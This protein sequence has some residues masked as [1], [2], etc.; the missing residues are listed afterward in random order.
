MSKETL[1]WLNNN[2]LIG[3]TEKRGT[4]WHYRE[5]LN[6]GE[7]N[8]YPGPIPVDD[9]L[10]RLFNFEVFPHPIYVEFGGEQVPVPGKKAWVCDDD[11]TVLGIFGDGYQGHAYSEWLIESVAKLLD[12]DLSIGSAGLL[13]NRGQAWVQVEVPETVVTPEGV[14]FRPHLLAATSFDG[15]LATVYKRSITNTVCDNTMTA[16]LGE[17]GEQVR[18]KHS[19][20]SHLR[21]ADARDALAIVYTLADDFASEV[22]K[23]CATPVTDRQ[24]VKHMDAMVPV[25]DTEGRGR[26]MAINKREQLSQ[27]WATDTRVAP[28][29]NTA[30]GVLQAHNTWFH[31]MSSVRGATRS[32]RNQENV[33][34]GRTATLDTTV[35][36]TLDAVLN[37]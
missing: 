21:L 30:W 22:E 1:Q 17:A 9:V 12:D 7:P 18:V 16:A 36:T 2:T 13:R 31:H 3:F 35:L 15:T 23:L 24:W 34:S 29:R 32:D 5:A 14:A 26:T 20:Y 27:L 25:P 11:G 4:A 33:L 6:N 28:W 37:N 8:H 10:R 19:K